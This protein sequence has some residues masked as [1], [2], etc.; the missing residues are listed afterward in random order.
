MK[1][2][3][4]LDANEPSNLAGVSEP[5][6]NL[7]TTA[8]ALWAGWHSSRPTEVAPEMRPSDLDEAYAIQDL[9]AAESGWP[10]LGWKVGVTD[11]ESQQRGG[12]TEPISG[13]VFRSFDSP[14]H[15]E[16]TAFPGRGIVEAEV[17]VQMGT[18]LLPRPAPY[19]REEVLA[20]IAAAAPAFE[21]AVT[22]FDQPQAMG[23]LSVI[24]DNSSGWAMVRGEPVPTA[25]TPLAERVQARLTVD[26]R[27]VGDESDVPG[28]DALHWVVWL[29]NHLSARD[30]AL[31]KG[32]WVCT[33]KIAPL[34][35]VT[36][37]ERF[38]A[39][40][41]QLGTAELNLV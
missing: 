5:E 3:I 11:V 27:V 24:A 41:G 2:S 37:P 16:L 26:G 15:V 7:A 20:G 12:L 25:E 18:T 4:D 36:G 32:A 34:R 8:A 40:F 22:R 38:V 14:A 31:E 17:A 30:L 21:L 1:G 29:A 10:V 23:M 9:L 35:R 13:R 33:G 28:Y 6:K 39:Q 19:G